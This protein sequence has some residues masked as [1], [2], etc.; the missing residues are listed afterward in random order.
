MYFGSIHYISLHNSVWNLG[1]NAGYFLKIENE[2]MIL[3]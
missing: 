2:L 1:C 3:R